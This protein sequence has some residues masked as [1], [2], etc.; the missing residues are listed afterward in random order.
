[1]DSSRFWADFHF[2]NT[3]FSDV[4]MQRTR[5]PRTHWIQPTSVRLSYRST[6]KDKDKQIHRTVK[7]ITGL[8]AEY[9]VPFPLSYIFPP[10]ALQAYNDILVFLIQIR[11][12]KYV[13][14]KILVRNSATGRQQRQELKSLYALRSRLSWVVNTLL[15][16][17]STYVRSPAVLPAVLVGSL[18][19]LSWL[20][21]HPS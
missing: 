17:F 8:T 15:D 21:G 4:I 20:L 10:A 5:A 12:A 7:S 13:L 18:R 6:T 16:F 9:A 1:M 11:R 2:L 19:S 14:D 3:A